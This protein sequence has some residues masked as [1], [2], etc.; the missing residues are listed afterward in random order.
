MIPWNVQ[1]PNALN[2]RKHKITKD[3][4]YKVTDFNHTL[5]YLGTHCAQSNVG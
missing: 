5:V 3:R 4:S 1:L 2:D